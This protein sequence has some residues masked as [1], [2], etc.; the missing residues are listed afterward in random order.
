[1]GDLVK[2]RFQRT[3]RCELDALW[4][5]GLCIIHMQGVIRSKLRSY[6]GSS[7][8]SY[9]VIAAQMGGELHIP[10]YQV[11]KLPSYSFDAPAHRASSSYRHVLWNSTL[12]KTRERAGD[13]HTVL[14]ALQQQQQHGVISAVLGSLARL[15]MFGGGEPLLVQASALRCPLRWPRTPHAPPPRRPLAR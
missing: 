15:G 11:T 14:M 4:R 3:W 6:C 8:A 5:Y 9:E 10:S 2:V 1:M 12:N 13:K 7:D